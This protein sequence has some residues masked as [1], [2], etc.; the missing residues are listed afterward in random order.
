VADRRITLREHSRAAATVRV[1][2]VTIRFPEF[3][4]S[5]GEVVPKA[6]LF[7]LVVF[8]PGFIQCDTSYHRLLRQWASAGYV[9]AAV[10]FPDTNCHVAKPDEA[11][12]V[13]QPGDVAFVI[14]RLRSQANQG[15]DGWA[16]LIAPARIGIAG[17]SDGGDTVAAMAAAS[18]CRDHLVRAVVVLAG[19]VWP[20]LHGSW[21][22]SPTPPMLFVQGS[23]DSINPVAASVQLYR[24]DKTGIRYYLNMLGADHLAPYEGN[25]KQEA[26]VALVTVDFLNQY[27]AGEHSVGAMLRAGHVP[28]IA[29]LGRGGK[30]PS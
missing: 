19:A 22:A 5:H 9:V 4:P 21:Y 18:C 25:G 13:N 23:A 2:R 28:G 27:L 12:L 26:V 1:L 8:A 24:G 15:G 20:A 7:P 30:I 11:D 6:G 10:N 3:V 14:R 16:G 17:Q 29:A